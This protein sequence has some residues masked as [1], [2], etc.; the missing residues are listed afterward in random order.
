MMLYDGFLLG[1]GSTGTDGASRQ[2][3]CTAFRQLVDVLGDFDETFGHAG[4]LLRK[5]D[6]SLEGGFDLRSDGIV[7]A[8]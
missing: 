3:R 8:F 2:A 4:C 6:G 7:A 1:L 5:P